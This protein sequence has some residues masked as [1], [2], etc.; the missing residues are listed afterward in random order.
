MVSMLQNRMFAILAFL[1]QVAFLVLFALFAKYDSAALPKDTTAKEPDE[2][3]DT[4][5]NHFYPC[6]SYLLAYT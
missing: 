2:H 1:V 5:V 6:K 4:Y 3:V